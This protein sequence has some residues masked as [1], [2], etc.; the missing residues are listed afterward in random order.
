MTETE[1]R[2]RRDKTLDAIVMARMRERIS[3]EDEE[4]EFLRLAAA[5]T[6]MGRFPMN[7]LTAPPETSEIFLPISSASS[8]V[9]T[10][11]EPPAVTRE[12]TSGN[13]GETGETQ[14]EMKPEASPPAPT[15]RFVRSE[16]EQRKTSESMKASWARRRGQE[17]IE[18]ATSARPEPALIP[19]AEQRMRV[20]GS[21]GAI[22]E[23]R[24]YILT[25]IEKGEGISARV[26]ENMTLLDTSTVRKMIAEIQLEA[27]RNGLG[28]KSATPV[29]PPKPRP[30]WWEESLM[31][32]CIYCG[33]PIEPKVFTRGYEARDTYLRREYCGQECYHQK[34]RQ[35][36]QNGR[37]AQ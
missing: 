24:M 23:A 34:R 31:R 18:E 30:P 37:T 9:E 3:G 4:S 6:L 10:P 21:S 1:F 22:F 17:A 32:K 7:G 26:V 25:C 19:Q 20:P 13:A 12:V 14:E 29:E 8:P 33:E 35:D 36:F 11:L 16:E 15:T 2:E 28:K 27:K 5:A